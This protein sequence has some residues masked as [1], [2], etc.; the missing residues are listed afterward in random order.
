MRLLTSL[1]AFAFALLLTSSAVAQEQTCTAEQV[2]RVTVEVRG[3]L[4]A[5]CCWK[6]T[7]L[8]HSSPKAD[9]MS[10]EVR[11]MAEQCMSKE[12]ILDDFARRHGE[13]ILAR[14]RRSGLGLWFYLGPAILLAI[15]GLVLAFRIIPRLATPPQEQAAEGP[16]VTSL[17]PGLDDAF[18]QEL[19]RLNRS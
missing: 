1:F 9:E 19:Q 5:N 18:E 14:P 8:N 6:D 2:D 11:R 16:P 10:A 4:M 7:L 15:T 13:S 3:E 17:S 12:A